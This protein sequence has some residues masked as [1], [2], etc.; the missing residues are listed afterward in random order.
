VD[1]PTQQLHRCHGHTSHMQQG[2][3]VG[4]TA[5]AK[6]CSSCCD[7]TATNWL[8]CC[9]TET[10]SVGQG[11]TTRIVCGHRKDPGL[12]RLVQTHQTIVLRPNKVWT[13]CPDPMWVRPM[14]NKKGA[15]AFQP[16]P[17]GDPSAATR[18]QQA[19][20]TQSRSGP[21]GPDLSWLQPT[22][23]ERVQALQPAPGCSPNAAT[24][25]TWPRPSWRA[26][27]LTLKP[28]IPGAG[29]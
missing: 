5:E 17:R 21:T 10:T 14:A 2:P 23:E 24:D 13:T 1:L 22:A 11:K 26:R 12:D 29:L 27:G 18:L 6:E 7:M 16:A 8:L 9:A 3:K 19:Q 15:H 25:A 28:N 20:Q 4:S